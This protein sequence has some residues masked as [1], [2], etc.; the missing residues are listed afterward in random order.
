MSGHRLDLVIEAGTKDKRY[1]RDIWEHCELFYMLVWRDIAVR[2]KQTIV[3]IVW[4]TR[5]FDEIVPFAEI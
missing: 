1:W 3:G 2:Y 5:K 4:A